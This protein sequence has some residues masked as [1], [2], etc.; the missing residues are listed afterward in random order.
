[1]EITAVKARE[2]LDSRGNPTVEV[3]VATKKGFS[4][5]IVP[6]GAST[7]IHEALELRDKDTRYNG[8][9]VRTAVSNVN[10]IIAGKII[11][12]DCSKQKELDSF[13][14]E[15]DGT[16]NKSRLGANAILGVSMAACRAAA[17]E[18]GK[19]LFEWIAEISDR[20]SALP[21]PSMNVINGGVHAGNKLDIQE[22][23]I[24]PTGAKSF[25]EAYRMCAETYHILKEIIKKKHG[26]DA[27]NVGDEG[28]FAP[29]LADSK[30]PLELLLSAIESAG[31]TGKIKLGMD[32]AASEFYTSEGYSFEGK[33]L[34]GKELGDIYSE[35]TQS[36]PIVSIED[37]FAQD[38]WGSWVEFTQENK[39]LQVVG[40]D[41]LVTNVSRINDAIKKKACNALLLKINQIGSISESIDAAKL[42]F[43][44]DWNVMVS[45]RSGETEDCFIADLVVGLGAGQIKS[46]APCRSE[47]TAKYNQLLRIEE[48]LGE[49]TRYEVNL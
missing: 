8:K 45:H 19:L 20:K 30:E 26:K 33:V 22:Y 25:S 47:R 46:G 7:G 42:S 27:I 2:V 32:A 12:F 35:L 9:G 37:P 23:M 21:T 18:Q 36:Y 13:L 39:K 40:D 15:I 29:P 38:D 3:E 44:N 34:D 49:K 48:E 17:C 10:N 14:L 11:G 43:E 41:L 24:L 1:M 31:Y 16:E 28:G 6:S 5:A 4:R